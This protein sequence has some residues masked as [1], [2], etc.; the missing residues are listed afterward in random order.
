MTTVEQ[1]MTRLLESERDMLLGGDLRGLT[2]ITKEKEALIP[3]MRSLDADAR[4]RLRLT[5]DQNHAL[6][7]AAMRGLRGAI[8][9]I[10]AIGGAHAPLQTYSAN[11]DRAALSQPRRRDLETRA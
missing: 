1:K 7:G 8:R 11:G 9:R 4:T 2:D 6:L 5:A 10:N 3:N